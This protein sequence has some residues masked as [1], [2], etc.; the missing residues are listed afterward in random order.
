MYNVAMEKHKA[1]DV[2][3]NLKAMDIAKYKSIA[4]AAWEFDMD[5]KRIY[6]WYIRDALEQHCLIAL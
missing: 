6:H 2:K 4:A 1:Y 5:W 3:F